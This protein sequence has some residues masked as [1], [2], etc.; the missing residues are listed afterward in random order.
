MFIIEVEQNYIKTSADG[1]LNSI[2][3]DAITMGLAVLRWGCLHLTLPVLYHKRAL[4]YE[5]SMRLKM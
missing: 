2:L 4:E 5:A 1:S 3:R